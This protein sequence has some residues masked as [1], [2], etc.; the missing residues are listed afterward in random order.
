ME[1]S[2]LKQKTK[3]KVKA[4]PQKR[5]RKLSRRWKEAADW[6]LEA[7]ILALLEGR[8]TSGSVEVPTASTLGIQRSSW[9]PLQ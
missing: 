3:T 1:G 2:K 6:S 5:K 4:N 8:G 9:H 7:R